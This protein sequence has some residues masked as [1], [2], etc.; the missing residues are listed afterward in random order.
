MSKY[1]YLNG[2][3]EEQNIVDVMEALIKFTLLTRE[4]G[5]FLVD[6]YSERRESAEAMSRAVNQAKLKTTMS[7]MDYLRIARA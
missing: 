2:S 5:A 6:R 1:F 7:R 4:L 3:I